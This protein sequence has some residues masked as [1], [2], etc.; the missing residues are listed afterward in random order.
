MA[1]LSDITRPDVRE[2][3]RE[4]LMSGVGYDRVPFRL[5]YPFV[6]TDAG[7]SLSARPKQNNDCTVRAVALA[8]GMEYDIAYDVLAG[9]GRKCGKGF[10]LNVWLTAQPWT[11]K[12]PFQAIK[13][14][15]R[16]NPATFVK[17]Y[18][19]GVYICKVAKHVFLV[20]DGV[21]Y[22]TFENRPDRCIYTAW[23]I[24]K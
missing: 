21:V 20:K 13:G 19:L 9:A 1:V 5:S 4:V 16:M 3:V 15:P 10:H 22:D 18:P 17:Q 6:R 7:R 11:R 23:E 8:L 24:L 2:K 12:I 14:K